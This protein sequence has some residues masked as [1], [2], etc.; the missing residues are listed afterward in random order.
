M[1]QIR[2]DMLRGEL[3]SL[4]DVA[5]QVNKNGYAT[6]IEKGAMDLQR[7]YFLEIEG[8]AFFYEKESERDL[9]LSIILQI[10]AK[11]SINT[12]IRK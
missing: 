5:K 11:K 1:G 4:L 6:T 7:A 2:H 8:F 3:D 9:D 12:K 10:F